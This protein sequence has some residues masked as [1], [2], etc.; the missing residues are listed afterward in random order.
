[1]SASLNWSFRTGIENG[2]HSLFVC[3][4]FNSQCQRSFWIVKV[5]ATTCYGFLSACAILCQL[6][7]MPFSMFCHY[8]KFGGF[9]YKV[10]FQVFHTQYQNKHHECNSLLRLHLSSYFW[11]EFTSFFSA[12]V[13][14]IIDL[15]PGGQNQRGGWTS[16]NQTA[17]R[18]TLNQQ[19]CHFKKYDLHYFHRDL[20][21]SPLHQI[22][23]NKMF[24]NVLI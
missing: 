6:K 21:K 8:Y 4:L 12:D 3:F 19:V 20:K 13:F 10:I 11:L 9:T 7:A 15:C 22:N 1:M 14:K 23:D 24:V 2:V 18:M 16:R 17:R 5:A